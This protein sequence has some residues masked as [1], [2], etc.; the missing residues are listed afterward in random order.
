MSKYESLSN[1]LASKH[2][3]ELS[4]T[5][6]E[7]EAI[8]GFKLPNSARTHRPW[9]ANS[10]HG[11]VQSRGWLDAGYQSEQVD[12]EGEQLTFKKVHRATSDAPAHHP[13]IGWAKGTVRVPAGVDLTAPMFSDAEMDS[14]LAEK[15]ANIAAGLSR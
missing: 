3:N 5:F 13:F 8:L 7:V 2:A 9:W 14:Y 10:A 6:A 4:M 12:L 1:Y 11:H 15:S